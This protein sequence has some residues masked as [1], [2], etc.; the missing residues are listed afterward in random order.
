MEEWSPLSLGILP[1]GP[2]PALSPHCWG[3]GPSSQEC[4]TAKHQPRASALENTASLP[5]P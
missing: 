4:K 2:G 1:C 5:K 3:M